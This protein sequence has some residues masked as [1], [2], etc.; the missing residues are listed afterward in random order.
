MRFPTSEIA[1]HS[2]P[3]FAYAPE[4]NCICLI[5]NVFLHSHPFLCQ[6]WKPFR[7]LATVTAVMRPN[8]Y[9]SY[10]HS[11][12]RTLIPFSFLCFLSMETSHWT[13]QSFVPGETS[14]PGKILCLL[15]FLSR[16]RRPPDIFRRLRRVVFHLPSGGKEQPTQ[17]TFILSEKETNCSKKSDRLTSPDRTEEMHFDGGMNAADHRLWCHADPH[18]NVVSFFFCQKLLQNKFLILFLLLQCVSRCMNQT[19]IQHSY[20]FEA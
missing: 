11:P 18:P 20:G 14:Q 16:T 9:S 12:P 5:F 13:C 3:D 19:I 1:T 7:A 6:G 15:S 4:T 17:F 2:H 8:S 10:P